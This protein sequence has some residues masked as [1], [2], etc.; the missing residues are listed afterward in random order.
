MNTVRSVQNHNA[1]NCLNFML[2]KPINLQCWSQHALTTWWQLP[3]KMQIGDDNW[4]MW[5]KATIVVC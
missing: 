1:L 4:F 3:L 2:N 5:R